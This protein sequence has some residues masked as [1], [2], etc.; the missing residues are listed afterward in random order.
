[1]TMNLNDLSINECIDVIVS[2]SMVVEL[3]NLTFAS[4]PDSFLFFK[5]FHPA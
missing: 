5:F 2:A 1:M 3:P 4:Y